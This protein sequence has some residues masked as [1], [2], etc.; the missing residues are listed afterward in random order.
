MKIRFSPLR[1]LRALRGKFTD[2]YE[3]P[4][5]VKTNAS[6][7]NAMNI[8]PAEETE[9]EPLATLWY[10]GWQDAHKPITPPELAQYRT[11]EDFRHRL[12]AN[13]PNLRVTG[14]KGHPTGFCIIKNDE[15]HQLYVAATA[16]G[17]GTG[18][19]LLADGEARLRAQGVKTAWLAC[20]IGND[21][22]A[23]F[24]E[25]NGWHLAGNRIVQLEI[26]KGLFPLEVW[27]YEKAL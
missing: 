21:R 24:Y 17:T 15:L 10:Q 25:K 3:V 26:P 1:A 9:I 4:M 7:G 27:R 14:P 2:F 20:A 6:Q 5:V 12:Q 13:L 8:R 22:A 16:R 19:A 18:A 23:A 11:R